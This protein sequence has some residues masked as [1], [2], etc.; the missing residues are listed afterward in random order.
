MARGYHP[1]FSTRDSTPASG[2]ALPSRLDPRLWHAQ[3]FSPDSALQSGPYTGFSPLTLP[4]GPSV[5][6][7][8]HYVT[9][10]FRS[11]GR[12]RSPGS[13]GRLRKAIPS[14]RGRVDTFPGHGHTWPR[15]QSR[16]SVDRP[17][18]NGLCTPPGTVYP[19]TRPPRA[20]STGR[21][22]FVV[23]SFESGRKC[24]FPARI[25]RI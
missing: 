6:G 16:A 13:P 19:G 15:T 25:F 9:D 12:G 10:R 4:T 22:D 20:E 8:C 1:G 23:F 11:P 2:C 21:G 14:P 3:R 24:G 5:C 17:P 7:R 18:P